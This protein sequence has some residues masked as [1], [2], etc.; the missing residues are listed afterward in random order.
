MALGIRTVI[1]DFPN[2]I[3]ACLISIT[4]KKIFPTQYVCTYKWTIV[5]FCHGLNLA[6]LVR[7]NIEDKLE[8]RYVLIKLSNNMVR[9]TGTSYVGILAW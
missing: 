9:R 6:G 2:F 3:W 7:E 4:H 5:R 8:N 1:Y